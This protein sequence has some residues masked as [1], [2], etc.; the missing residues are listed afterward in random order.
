MTGASVGDRRAE[1][2]ARMLRERFAAEPAVVASAAGRVNLI[3]E[4]T[5]Y[6]GGEVL[7]IAIARRTIVAVR[8]NGREEWRAA[9][10]TEDVAGAFPAEPSRVGAWWDYVAG[11]VTML[12]QVGVAVPPCDLAVWS[13]VPAGAGLSSS[14]ALEVATAVA[15]TRL[16]GAEM[17]LD[18][19]ALLAQRAEV[20]YVGVNSG[21]M[22]QFASALGRPGEALHVWCDTATY[23]QIPMR[24]AVLIFDTAVPRSLRSS[25]FNTRRAECEGTE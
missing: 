18:Q 13:D 3:G 21:I 7:P 15:L 1:L 14:A 16:V 10:A 5:D 11:V 19:L 22:D 12:R 23:E 2:A 6:N 9:S 8:P 4:H 20:E 24:D 25:Q 17:A